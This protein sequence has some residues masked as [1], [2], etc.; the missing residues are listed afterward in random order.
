M[1]EIDLARQQAADAQA[2]TT[3][4]KKASE[5]S[6]KLRAI[7]ETDQQLIALRES[8]GRIIAPSHKQLA[9]LRKAQTQLRETK[10]QLDAALI[11]LTIDPEQAF[12]LDCLTGETTGQKAATA[13]ERI[14]LRGS[15]EVAI[16][17]T[18]IGVIRATGPAG[19]V[20][21]LRAAASKA[22]QEWQQLTTSFGGT[23]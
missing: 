23:S 13:G 1:P 4:A 19:S 5:L 14:V 8:R 20:E 9:A 21:E 10:L 22:E 15:P 12:T 17:I 2:F 18:G 3:A 16:R 6:H 11:T 7:R